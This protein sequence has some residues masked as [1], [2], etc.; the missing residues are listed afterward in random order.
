M[1][2]TIG[3]DRLGSG[4]KMELSYKNYERSTHDLSYLFR[5]SMAAGTLVPFMNQLALP[6]DNLSIELNTEV[7]TLPT[8]GPLFGSY[9]V[10]LDVFEVPLRLYNA[11]LHMNKLGIGMD[12]KNIFLPQIRLRT[13]NSAAYV[14]TF[15]DNEQVNP[16]SLVKYLGISGLGRISG[17]TNPA[18]RDFNACPFLAYWDIYKNYYSNKQE[19]V[20]Y[21]ILSDETNFIDSATPLWATITTEANSIYPFFDSPNERDVIT[22]QT[23]II[24]Y[25]SNCPFIDNPQMIPIQQEGG[26]GQLGDLL[27]NIVYDQTLQQVR[28]SVMDDAADC[29]IRNDTFT[30]NLHPVS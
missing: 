27:H 16:S 24:Q 28:G 8:I 25:P 13:N 22:G 9:K 7:L 5:S 30:D 17:E 29:Y 2:T 15:Q 10:Q 18:T 11:K 20:G 26:P 19:E 12:M 23:V 4:N 21:M 14:Q 6:G 1:K 3:G